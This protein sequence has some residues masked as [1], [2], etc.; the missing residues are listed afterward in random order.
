MT[1]SGRIRTF[2][3]V[4]AEKTA[5]Y[6][7]IMA[8][9][10]AAKE[11]F[12]LHLRPAEVARDLGV[13]AVCDA[14]VDDIEP[15]LKQL[16]EWGNLQASPDT[17]DVARVEDF[18]R[19]R[20]LYQLSRAGEAAERAVR[21]YERTILQPGELQAAALADIRE[22]LSELE[23][24]AVISPLDAAKVYQTFDQLRRR[25]EELTTKAQIFLGT[26]RRSVDLHAGDEAG[27]V[28][29]K[30][31]LIDYLER[32]VKE[33]MMATVSIAGGIERIDGIGVEPLLVAVARREVV[34]RIDAEEALPAVLEDWRAR[35]RGLSRWFFGDARD[36][37]QAEILRAAARAA[38]PALLTAAASMHDRRVRR[39]D[40]YA[41]W[42]ALARWFAEA[43]SDEDGHRLYRVAF[44]LAPAR[45]LRINA[46]S[47][48]AMD[49][50]M[51]APQLGWLDAPV[52]RLT[53]RFRATGRH[54]RRGAERKV[55]DRSAARARLAEI[56]QEEARQIAA[57][58]RRLCVGRTRL[59]QL[60]ELD[61]AAF[62]LFL[63]LLADALSSQ[64]HPRA[65]VTATSADGTLLVRLE[66]VGDGS[67][68]CV[69]GSSGTLRGPDCWIEIVDARA[70]RAE[71]AE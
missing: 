69:R 27:F 6:R 16:E 2:A 23:A 68:A 63:D 26:L 39:T 60:E 51:I 59:S 45:H 37:S 4:D 29:Y 20:R 57:A 22:L 12:V 54:D 52:L 67:M 53:P 8:V 17:A 11:R 10:F 47:L 33:L 28:F 25:F 5:L 9:F 1:T 40:R 7:G 41:D 38:I 46:E 32:F 43:P 24:L 65:S 34:D 50:R 66:P 56:A 55:E 3:Y 58:R 18:Y 42:R 13:V 36:P 62:E 64:K 48:A 35:W 31:R 61:A 70:P 30:D 19:E 15:A 49:E 14:K 71:A 21:D 44:A